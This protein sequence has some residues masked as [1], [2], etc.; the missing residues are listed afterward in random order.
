LLHAQKI[1]FTQ[2]H[3]SV[4]SFQNNFQTKISQLF[5]QEKPKRCFACR[6]L[7]GFRQSLRIAG[8]YG[9]GFGM[10][11]G[12]FWLVGYLLIKTRYFWMGFD[13]SFS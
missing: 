6:T 4:K 3:S 7:N 8:L 9:R 13:F 11:R 12:L 2:Q 10:E 5:L 1:L